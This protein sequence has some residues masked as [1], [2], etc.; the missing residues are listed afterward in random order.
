LGPVET[1][2]VQIIVQKAEQFSL[3]RQIILP[4]RQ[5]D[6]VFGSAGGIWRR[7]WLVADR[8]HDFRAVQEERGA[9]GF[10]ELWGFGHQPGS[11]KILVLPP[12]TKS[13]I[14]PDEYEQLQDEAAQDRAQDDQTGVIELMEDINQRQDDRARQNIAIEY[15][16]GHL[17]AV[18]DLCEG[19]FPTPEAAEDPDQGESRERAPVF[20]IRQ[21][22]PRAVLELCREEEGE[23]HDRD[24]QQKQ[25]ILNNLI[26]HADN[27][28]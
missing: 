14:D 7:V 3:I 20:K 28:I 16:L 6:A 24:V 11:G 10:L 15:L 17:E 22:A 21:D 27:R 4:K 25:Q 18:A 23:H 5:H 26:F 2:Q 12:E 9:L 13:V 8:R 1:G 19:V